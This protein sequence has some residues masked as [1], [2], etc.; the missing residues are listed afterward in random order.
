[1][2][3]ELP[4]EIQVAGPVLAHRFG[5]LDLIDE[6]RLYVRLEA[7]RCSGRQRCA[8][9][10]GATPATETDERGAGATIRPHVVDPESALSRLFGAWRS[11]RFVEFEVIT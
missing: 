6:Y 10:L 7:D 11:V 1:M 8:A 4:G 2:K 9:R 3:K 5:E